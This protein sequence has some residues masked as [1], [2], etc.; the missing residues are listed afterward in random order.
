MPIVYVLNLVGDSVHDR[1]IG[2]RKKS[3]AAM[4]TPHLVQ[5]CFITNIKAAN[6]KNPARKSASAS[7]KT[8]HLVQQCCL[9][10]VLQTYQS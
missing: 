4:K 1:D 3:S 7:M 2:V 9:S 10:R 8:P 5:Q 6:V